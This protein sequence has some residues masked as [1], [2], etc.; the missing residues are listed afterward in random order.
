MKKL[1]AVFILA[2]APIA[3]QAQDK[4]FCNLYGS[5]FKSPTKQGADYWVY[6]EKESDAFADML[7]FEEE[8]KLYADEPGVWFFVDNKGLADYSIF[9][10]KDKSEADFTIY[11]TDSPTFAGCK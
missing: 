8:N 3:L 5:F 1:L 10:T 9:F 6:V 11:F 7:I 2:L 4:P